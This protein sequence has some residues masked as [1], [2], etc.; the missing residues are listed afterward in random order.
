MARNYVNNRELFEV[1][2]DFH[3][4]CQLAEKNGEEYPPV[5]N[6]VGECILQIANRL[7]TKPNFNNYTFKEEMISDGIENCI[8]Y[9]KNFNPAKSN[10]PFAYF[11]Q[12]I[13]F[14][15]I[16]RIQKERKQMYIKYKNYD[17]MNLADS[18]EGFDIQTKELNEQTQE[19]I[20]SFEKTLTKGKR[21]DKVS[22]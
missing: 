22:S 4:R 17:R 18:V 12:I 3:A 16:R 8:L 10:N 20:R 19:F 9:I 1:M 6:Y 21:S 5:P 11:T 7:A 13:K 2:S 14:A 15:F